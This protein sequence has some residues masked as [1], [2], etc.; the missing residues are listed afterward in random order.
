VG[1]KKGKGRESGKNTGMLRKRE[2]CHMLL[3]L[4]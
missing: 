4:N 1:R 2:L 3:R